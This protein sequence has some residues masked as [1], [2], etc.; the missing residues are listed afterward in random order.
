MEEKRD[1]LWYEFDRIVNT[2]PKSAWIVPPS[3]VTIVTPDSVRL[4]VPQEQMDSKLS[5]S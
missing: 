1:S 5:R 2:P 3:G 4:E